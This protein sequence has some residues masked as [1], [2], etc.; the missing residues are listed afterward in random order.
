MRHWWSKSGSTWAGHRARER[1]GEALKR[2]LTKVLM[3]PKLPKV[4][5]RHFG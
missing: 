2:Q 3:L 5:K 4:P 1:P